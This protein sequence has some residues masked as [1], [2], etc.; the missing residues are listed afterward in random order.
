MHKVLPFTKAQVEKITKKYPTP[1]YLYEENGIRQTA[2][3]FQQIFG[4]LSGYR[5]Y[6]AVKALPNPTIL[7]ILRS[8]GMGADCSSLGELVLAEKAGFRGENIMFTSNNTPAEEYCRA[9]RLGAIIN[10]DDITHIPFFR[11]EVGRLPN[12]VCVRYNPGQLKSG[13]QIIGK[14]TEAKY[15]MTRRQILEAYA[16]LKK[17]GVKRFGLH[18]MAASNELKESYFI[19]TAQILF[20]LAVEI[21]KKL[22]ITLEFIN[23]GGGIGIPYRPNEKSVNLKKIVDGVMQAQKKAGLSD[24]KIFTESGRA[25]TGPHGYLV[26]RAIHTKDTYRHYIGAD[27]CMAN[28]MRPAL[29]GAYHHITVLGKENA[30]ATAIYDVV[31]SLCENNDKFAVQRRL[32]KIAAGDLLAIHDAGAHSHAMGFNYN[33][34]LRSAELLLKADERVKLIRRAETLQDYFAT[35][36]A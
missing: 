18:T 29:Y 28:L 35:L 9:V 36:R 4:R 8:E 2:R 7:K 33:A 27:A 21:Q 20:D 16:L 12:L 3:Q 30:K 1:F 32:P 13:N 23:L 24:L 10:F 6:F 26:M 14:P 5:N 17:R 19:E 15:G 22:G 11:K 34:K 25:V 31:G